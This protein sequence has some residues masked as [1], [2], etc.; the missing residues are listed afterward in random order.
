METYTLNN[1]YIISLCQGKV[2]MSTSNK[3]QKYIEE[4]GKSFKTLRISTAQKSLRIFA[5]EC[6]VPSATLSRIE[7]GQRVPNIIVLKK[8]ASGFDWSVTELISKIEENI[9]DNIK[10]IE[11]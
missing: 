2:L 11:I 3:E 1:T 9:P 4:F 7:N 10:N 8:L 5:Y 6:D